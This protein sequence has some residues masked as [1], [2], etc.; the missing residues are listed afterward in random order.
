MAEAWGCH[1]ALQL[2]THLRPPERLARVVG[3]NL[4]VVRFGAGTARLR[5]PAMQGLLGPSISRLES[6]G[7]VLDWWAVRCRLNAAADAIATSALFAAA[8]LARDGL[9]EPVLRYVWY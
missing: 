7:W 5:R 2:L 1:A 6:A 8:R 9:A 3:D 4:A